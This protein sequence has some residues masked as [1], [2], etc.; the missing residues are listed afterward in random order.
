[1][2]YFTK[3]DYVIFYQTNHTVNGRISSLRY[4]AFEAGFANKTLLK[5]MAKELSS[6]PFRVYNSKGGQYAI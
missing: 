5:R 6:H 3:N 4:P 1:M 2:L